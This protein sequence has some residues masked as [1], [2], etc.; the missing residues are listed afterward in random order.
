MNK[1][2]WS[3]VLLAAMCLPAGIAATRFAKPPCVVAGEWAEA[4]VAS[5]PRTHA[6]FERYSPLYRRAIY[7]HLS[8]PD[9]VEFWRTHLAPFA[10]R[11]DLSS[12]QRGFLEL[13]MSRLPM[14]LNGEAGRQAI[15][16]ELRG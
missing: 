5:L 2:N 14:Y 1:R 6:A 7:T 16:S 3:L 10:A 15:K 13:V 9:R 4:N 8:V 12:S 11:Q